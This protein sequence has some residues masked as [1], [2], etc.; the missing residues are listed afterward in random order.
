MEAKRELSGAMEM[1]SLQEYVYLLQ[2][3]KLYFVCVFYYLH[4]LYFNKIYF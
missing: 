2:L 1:V 3:I 4:K